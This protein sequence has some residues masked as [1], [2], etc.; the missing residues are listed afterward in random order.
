MSKA[1]DNSFSLS[2]PSWANTNSGFWHSFFISTIRSTSEPLWASTF[3]PHP[4]NAGKQRSELRLLG[5]IDD[6]ELT[7]LGRRAAAARSEEEVARVWCDWIRQTGDA[8]LEQLNERLPAFKRAVRQFWRLQ[9]EVR[10]FFLANVQNRA[11]KHTL[12][13]IELLCNAS[14][15]VQELPLENFRALTPLIAQVERLP[16]YVREAVAEYHENKGTRGWELPD[17]RIMPLAWR[18]AEESRPG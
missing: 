16:E 5:L 10:D 8:A 7:E 6:H 2:V 9:P 14:D 3:L 4:P 13:T 15:I 1:P 11:E 12:Q 18:E 17:R